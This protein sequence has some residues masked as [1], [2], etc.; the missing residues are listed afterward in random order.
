[1][2]VPQKLTQWWDRLVKLWWHS[3]LYWLTFVFLT[4]ASIITILY[5]HYITCTLYI[6]FYNYIII[7]KLNIFI[8]SC[9][10]ITNYLTWNKQTKF[11]MPLTKCKEFFFLIMNKKPSSIIISLFILKKISLPYPFIKTQTD[12]VVA[13][14]QSNFVKLLSR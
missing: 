13:N 10:F 14:L 11:K 5:I 8:K 2:C 7:S 1:M 12:L 4:W 6:I 3:W 9:F